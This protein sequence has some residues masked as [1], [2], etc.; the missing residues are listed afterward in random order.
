MSVD[1]NSHVPIY[2]QIIQH[3]SGAIAAGVIRAG[4]P[5]P[6]IRNVAVDLVVNP[7][8]VQR[9]FQELERRGLIETRKGMRV[10]AAKDAAVVATRQSEAASKARFE[11]GIAIG[12][13]A[14]IP[15]TRIKALFDE[16]M[17]SKGNGRRKAEGDKQAE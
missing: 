4:E 8:T 17:R 6:S 9:A 1:P 10:L 5:L 11:D 7:N 14:G 12:R 16:S 2:E 3:L 13:A 15:K